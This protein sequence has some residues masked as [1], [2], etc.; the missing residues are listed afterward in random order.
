MKNDTA[1]T[2]PSRYESV[3]PPWPSLGS[4]EIHIWLVPLV[5]SSA[6]CEETLRALL[7]AEERQ[8]VDRFRCDQQKSAYTIT[9][10]TLRQLLGHYLHAAPATIQIGY[11]ARGKPGLQGFA[12]S[13]QFNLSHSGGWSL[14]ALT[15]G[16]HV[17]IDLQH[18]RPTSISER[19]RLAQRFFSHEEFQALCQLP[20]SRIEAA[21]FA[22]WTRKEAYIKCH[23]LGL[24][25][26]LAHFSV[27][28]DPDRPARLLSTPWRPADVTACHMHDLPAPEGYRAALVW[29]SQ[30]HKRIQLF[31]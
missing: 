18:V 2:I 15:R 4:D 10:G 11:S 1:R 3:T 12:P 16:A 5:P 20:S 13:L 23:G 27:S 21:F 9:R 6:T 26:S 29:A 24:A 28:M 8:R 25:L 7:S 30:H 31:R 17:G 19:L 22:G 14:Q